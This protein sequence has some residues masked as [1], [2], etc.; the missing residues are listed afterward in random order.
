MDVAGFTIGY[1]AHGIGRQIRKA[2]TR[3]E[4]KN[5]ETRGDDE[6]KDHWLSLYGAKPPQKIHHSPDRGGR[7][8]NAGECTG[9]TEIF[10]PPPSNAGRQQPGDLPT[11]TESPEPTSSSR[12]DVG[13]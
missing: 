5:L 9:R 10:G 4:L 3:I 2:R 6:L 8:P 11:T 1:D 12:N 7:P 13:A